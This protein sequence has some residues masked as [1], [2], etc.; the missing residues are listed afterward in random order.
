[1]YLLVNDPMKEQDIL[2]HKRFLKGRNKPHYY[3]IWQCFCFLLSLTW[4]SCS[5][6]LALGIL[7]ISLQFSSL[8]W[9]RALEKEKHAYL[10]FGHRVEIPQFADYLF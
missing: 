10:F 8:G 4:L 9:Q 2:K 5:S 6:G 7:G 1:M 3:L